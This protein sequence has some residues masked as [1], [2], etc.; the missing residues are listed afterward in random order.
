MLPQRC[1][2]ADP[3][4]PNSHTKIHVSVCVCVSVCLSVFERDIERV[5]ISC[6][7]IIILRN[8]DQVCITEYRP[9]MCQMQVMHGITE[10]QLKILTFN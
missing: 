2:S 10:S 1:I 4:N 3:V 7:Y 8:Y 9:A 6:E 5:S